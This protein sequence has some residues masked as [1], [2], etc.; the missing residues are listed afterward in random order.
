MWPGRDSLEES[1]GVHLV[2]SIEEAAFVVDSRVTDA[3]SPLSWGLSRLTAF[4]DDTVDDL[5]A[6]VRL[7]GFFVHESFT[8]SELCLSEFFSCG[9]KIA[10]FEE[11]ISGFKLGSIRHRPGHRRPEHAHG[12]VPTILLSNGVQGGQHKFEMMNQ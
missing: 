1:E 12:N 11:P 3:T 5:V 8:K 6:H 2:D 4:G 10:A 7:P 9:G